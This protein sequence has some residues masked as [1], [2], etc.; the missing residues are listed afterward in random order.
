MSASLHSLIGS[1]PA[2]IDQ[3]R[4]L[5]PEG[6]PLLDTC[7]I[8]NPE[9]TQLFL[10]HLRPILDDERQMLET[11]DDYLFEPLNSQ[12]P[13]QMS[14]VERGLYFSIQRSLQNYSSR[15]RTL[16][17]DQGKTSLGEIRCHD[18]P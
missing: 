4:R 6:T 5:V 13:I 10:Q 15:A 1:H 8:S 14:C 3:A 11:F 18:L 16:R 7:I 12:N 2:G 9:G 17:K